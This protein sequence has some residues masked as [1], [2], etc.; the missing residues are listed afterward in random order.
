MTEIRPSICRFCLAHCPILV[1]LED[2]R[3]T[4]VVGDPEAPLYYGYT[5]PKGRALPEQHNHPDRLIHSMKRGANGEHHRVA[6][7]TAMDEIAAK[8]SALVDQYGPRSVALYVGTN[9]LPYPASPGMANAW[10]RGIGSPMFFTSNTIDQPG[11]Q[12]ASALHGGWQAGEHSFESS[13]SWM[14]LGLNPLISKSA[15]VPSQNPGRKLKEAVDGGMQLVVIDPRRTETARR[16]KLHLQPRPGE[17]PTILAGLIRIVLS[18]ALYDE[19]FV[20]AN[21]IGLKDLETAVAPFTPNYVA[22]RAG[23]DADDLVKA[24]RIFGGGR[25]G[26]A[27]SG[28]GPNFATHGNL[29]EYLTLC[30]NT[31]CGRWNRAGEPMIRPNVMMPAYTA[32]AQPYKP[33]RAWGYGE[34]MR[35]RGLG[36]TTSGM[37][38][39]ALADEILLEGEGQVKALFCL[40]GNPMMAWPNQEKTFRAMQELELLVTLDVEMSATSQMADYAIATKLTIET[41]GMSQPGEMLKFFGPTLGFNRPYAQYAE[42]LV[43]P[44]VGGEGIEAW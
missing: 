41:P 6:P 4:K 7:E 3:P 30:L 25:R 19:E 39:A 32:K 14:L 40:G 10:L 23:I 38:T 16:A 29:S 9:S 26:I 44:R 11:K 1:T 22:E 8:V 20:A 31:L 34:Q 35:V 24:A 28:T 5:C 15:G 18:E 43:V 13:D 27:V 36:N 37:P 33:Y 12:I 2:G 42:R 17:D 21:A